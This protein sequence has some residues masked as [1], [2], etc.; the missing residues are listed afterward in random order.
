VKDL[1]SFLQAISHA[2]M[3]LNL[4]KCGFAKGEVR[5]VGQ[6]RV[7]PNRIKAIKDMKIPQSKKQIRQM[8]GFSFTLEITSQISLH[9]LNL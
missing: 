6:R 2:G 9:L 4:K 1:E 7:D 8:V 5:F 3:T